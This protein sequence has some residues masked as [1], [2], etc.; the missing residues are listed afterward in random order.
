MSPRAIVRWPFRVLALVIVLAGVA[1][2]AGRALAWRPYGAG[3]FEW[4]AL[5]A[6]PGIAWLVR[7]AWS[8][9]IRG[10]PP[11][12]E[13]WPF[14]SQEVFTVYVVLLLAASCS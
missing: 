13:C 11:A 4:R 5:L 2:V 12:F 8:S 7:V 1:A 10:R 14:A 9:A 3:P 6:L